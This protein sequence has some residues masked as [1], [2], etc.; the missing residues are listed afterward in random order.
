[1]ATKLRRRRRPWLR[2][3]L[4]ASVTQSRCFCRLFKASR[5]SLSVMVETMFRSSKPLYMLFFLSWMGLVIFSSVVY[6]AEKGDFDESE[7]QPL[8][9]PACDVAAPPS[10]SALLPL[11]HHAIPCVLCTTSTR[12]RH[13]MLST[14]RVASH[15]SCDTHLP[16]Q[17]SKPTKSA[18]ATTAWCRRARGTRLSL[19]T[20]NTWPGPTRAAR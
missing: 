2:A 16:S 7:H 13:N 3:K 5:G 4:P 15:L 19:S 1:M 9:L 12:I 10:L 20:V 17:R 6:Y 8:R 18:R 14:L 11:A